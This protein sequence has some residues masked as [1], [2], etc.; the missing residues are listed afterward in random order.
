MVNYIRNCYR[1]N[2]NQYGKICRGHDFVQLLGMAMV[3]ANFSSKY[4]QLK[5]AESY[6]AADFARTTLAGNIRA[7]ARRFGMVVM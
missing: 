1:L 7:F 3:N 6:D 4:V 2:D 5:I